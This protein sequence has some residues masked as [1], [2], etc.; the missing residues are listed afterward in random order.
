MRRGQATAN[1]GDFDSGLRD[2]QRAVEMK[3]DDIYYLDELGAI[4]LAKG[5]I[6]AAM[7]DIDRALAADSSYWGGTGV[8][9]YYLGGA[10]DKSEAI[11]DRAMKDNADYS[12][13]WL[14]KAL[15]QKARGDASG[16]AATLTAGRGVAGKNWP[17]ALID[18]VA[19][20]I[21]EDRLRILATAS[22]NKTQSERLCEINFY[23]GEL[24]YLAGDKAK[25]RAALKQAVDGGIY[26]YLE[27]AAAKARLAQLND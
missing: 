3:G 11:A 27:Y 19:G 20:K 5:D 16:A 4:H 18:F 14:W 7:A 24:A 23:R 10:Y 21:D 26:Y 25:A 6:T 2:V 8:L 22:D 12:Y 17:A 15:A 1:L 9:A 13:W